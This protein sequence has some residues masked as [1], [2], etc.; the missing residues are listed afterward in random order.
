MWVFPW[1]FNW[2]YGTRIPSSTY[3]P[4]KRR[5]TTSRYNAS[6]N[7]TYAFYKHPLPIS[8]L[9]SLLDKWRPKRPTK[10]H[11]ITRYFECLC[12]QPSHEEHTYNDETW[13][14]WSQTAV[15]IG[16][17]FML[18]ARQL[19]RSLRWMLRPREL[20]DYCNFVSMYSSQQIHLYEFYE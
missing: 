5:K 6:S 14:G 15:L 10:P 12:A 2:W 7:Y 17:T 18:I 11:E 4:P 20:L 9:H 8:D 19:A 3:L 13:D 16:K 1:P